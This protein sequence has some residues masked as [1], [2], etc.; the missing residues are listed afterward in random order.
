MEELSGSKKVVGVSTKSSTPAPS[1]SRK[2]GRSLTPGTVLRDQPEPTPWP[3]PSEGDT[4]ERPPKR[5]RV[6]TMVE[7]MA[8]ETRQPTPN[9]EWAIEMEEVVDV[10]NM[11]VGEF[12][13]DEIGDTLG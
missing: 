12:S 4:E 2:R 13:V 11:D 5:S 6:V 3:R 9:D 1:T 10:F 8:V 7:E